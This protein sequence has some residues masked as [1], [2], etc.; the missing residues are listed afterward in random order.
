MAQPRLAYFSKTIIIYFAWCILI[1]LPTNGI[2]EEPNHTVLATHGTV[3]LTFDDGPNPKITPKILKILEKYH[4]NATFFLT[5][6]NAQK[7]PELVKKIYNDGNAI[8]NHSI[9][10]KPF[11]ALSDSEL[12]NESLGA[13]SILEKI[14]EKPV[15][16]IRPPYSNHSPSVIY[17]LKSKN[18]VTVE[19]GLNS[20]DYEF[21]GVQKLV[22]CTVYHVQ[23]GYIIDF[24]D[25]PD[26]VQNDQ[27]VK[28]LPQI[29]EGI[30]KKNLKFSTLKTICN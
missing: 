14:I 17:Y 6:E 1:S 21:P 7:Y 2:A 24:H 19:G 11:T 5:G 25:G 15:N 22:G 28:A 9:T 3:A 26:G 10:H 16:C 23:S 27:L 4:I 29:I 13:K 30:Q 20:F 18:L 12:Q 8:G